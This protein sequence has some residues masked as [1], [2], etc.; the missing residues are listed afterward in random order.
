MGD[1]TPALAGM[2]AAD[3]RVDTLCEYLMWDHDD[4]GWRGRG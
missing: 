1:I 3:P 2:T 4:D